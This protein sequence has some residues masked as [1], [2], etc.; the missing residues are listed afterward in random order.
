MCDKGKDDGG[1]WGGGGGGR[2]GGVM[3][4]QNSYAT[5]MIL[6]FY[7]TSCLVFFFNCVHVCVRLES[8]GVHHV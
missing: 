8:A 7:C 1:F 6:T 3:N 4:E 2:G 5:S